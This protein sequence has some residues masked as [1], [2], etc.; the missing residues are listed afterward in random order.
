MTIII[1]FAKVKML[2]GQLPH[3]NH[4]VETARQK[5]TA[6]VVVCPEYNLITD[7]THTHKTFNN[8]IH[9]RTAIQNN[10]ITAT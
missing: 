10:L 1:L 9:T 3:K 6:L 8:L 4:T 7:D 2:Q 5:K